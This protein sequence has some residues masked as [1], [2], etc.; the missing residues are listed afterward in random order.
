[1]TKEVDPDARSLR[2]SW[3]QIEELLEAKRE[4]VRT[5]EKLLPKFLKFMGVEK[6]AEIRAT[7]YDKAVQALT[8]KADEKS[9]DGKGDA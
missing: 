3:S 2:T 5:P 8:P 7:D 4:T 1:M 9:D 6:L